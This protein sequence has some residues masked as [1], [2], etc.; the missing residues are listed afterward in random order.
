MIEARAIADY[1]DYKNIEGFGH[2]EDE[3]SD[4]LV[5]HLDYNEVVSKAKLNEHLECDELVEA[6]NTMVSS[7][8]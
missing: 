6:P 4:N 5:E 8:F 7:S 2:P 3:E 1:A